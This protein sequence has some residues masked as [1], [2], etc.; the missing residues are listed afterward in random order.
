M[1]PLPGKIIFTVTDDA[2]LASVEALL[3]K[4]PKILPN[5]LSYLENIGTV[6]CDV[7]VGE[8][9]IIVAQ[10]SEE[11]IVQSVRQQHEHFLESPN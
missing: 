5:S 11:K 2:N 6:M 3:R 4:Y 1:M 7:P 9:D 10:L 8:E